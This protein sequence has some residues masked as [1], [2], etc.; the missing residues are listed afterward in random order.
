MS[1]DIVT[2]GTSLG[3]L[4]AL[5]TILREIPTDFRVPIVVAQH[6]SATDSEGFGSILGQYSRLPIREVEDKDPIQEGYVYI[7]PAGYHLLIERNQFSLSTDDPV[8]FARPSI[9]VLFESAAD[10][11]GPGLVAVVLTGASRDGSAGLARV[12]GQGGYTIVQDPATA[13]AELMPRAAIAAV[14]VDQI[15]PIES[16]AEHLTTVCRKQRQ[17]AKK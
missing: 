13:E 4:Q 17:S 1:F 6:R 9:D 12:K 15:L 8:M 11:Y 10:A 7:S 5:I 16:I 14:A 2:V 3:G